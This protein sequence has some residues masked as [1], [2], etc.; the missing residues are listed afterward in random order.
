MHTEMN[1]QHDSAAL[2]QAL[3]MAIVRNKRRCDQEAAEWR[4]KSQ[5]LEQELQAE[6][7]KQEQLQQWVT[8]AL[9][10]QQQQNKSPSLPEQSQPAQESEV[11]IFLPPLSAAGGGGDGGH[12][13]KS[14]MQPAGNFQG[15]QQQVALAAAAA[16]DTYSAVADVLDGKAAALSSMLLTN[17]QMLQQLSGKQPSP[18]IGSCAAEAAATIS[19]FITRT[20]LRAPR[21]LLSSAY[22]KQSAAVLAAVLAAPAPSPA[23]TSAATPGDIPQCVQQA[24]SPEALALQ[25]VQLMLQLL[26]FRAAAGS[27]AAATPSAESGAGSSCAAAGPGTAATLMLQQLS[28]FPGTALLLCLAAAQRVQGYVQEL[29]EANAAVQHI[30]LAS[31][32]ACAAAAE[33]ALR[34]ASQAFQAS[35][36]LLADLVSSARKA[37]NAA[38][39]AAS[40]QARHLIWVCPLPTVCLQL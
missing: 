31:F 17:V 19:N 9:Q 36:E 25:V 11:S 13:S 21:S 15:L 24:D 12:E 38:D 3:A 26:A 16:G 37:H 40:L 20:L 2:R 18:A 1:D 23:N 8:A 30:S 27:D 14:Q 29:Q 6:R 34:V 39:I 32:G 22:M 33:Q 7:D 5:R 28:V 35:L 4:A 10:Q